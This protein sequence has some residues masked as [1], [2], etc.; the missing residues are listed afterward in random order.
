M[1]QMSNPNLNCNNCTKTVKF[2]YSYDGQILPRR[3]D[4]VLRYVGGCTRVLSVDR[5]VTFAELMVKFGELCG[6]SMNLKCK[7]PNEDLDVLISV[8]SDEDL[9]NL[10]NEYDRFSEACKKEMKIR[11]VLFPVQSLKKISPPSSPMLCDGS[12]TAKVKFQS[13]RAVQRSIQHFPSN[14]LE[15][16]PVS[17]LWPAGVRNAAGNARCCP[18]GSPGRR[19]YLLPYSNYCQ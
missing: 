17:F 6:T 19:Q 1:T 5:S 18:H 2:L 14:W 9:A 10:I 8:K 15:S 3:N 12:V 13:A 7:L 11:A 16:K 4:G